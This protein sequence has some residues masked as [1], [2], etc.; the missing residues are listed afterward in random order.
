MVFQLHREKGVLSTSESSDKSVDPGRN[1]KSCPE[2]SAVNSGVG[3]PV[4]SG[5]GTSVNPQI[6]RK[7]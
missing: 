1:Y 4:N 5:S 6:S 2:G 3:A 7:L